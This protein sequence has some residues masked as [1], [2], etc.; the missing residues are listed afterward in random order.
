MKFFVNPSAPRPEGLG[1][2]P[3]NGSRIT[4]SLTGFDDP[5]LCSFHKLKVS[6]A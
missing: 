4:V 5:N 3:P 1:L 2:A 6:R